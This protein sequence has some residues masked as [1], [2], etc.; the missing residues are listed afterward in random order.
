MGYYSKVHIAVPIKD[1]VAMESLLEDY[2][3]S[4]EFTIGGKDY[5]YYYSDELKWYDEFE[6]VKPVNTFI[7]AD[8]YDDA[9]VEGRAM[10]SIGEDGRLG[11]EVGDWFS[12]FELE[13]RIVD[14]DIRSKLKRKKQWNT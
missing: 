1:K 9:K 13:T 6:D 7:Q 14:A 2:W 4:F 3:D 12:I 10:I 11:N 8:P 5:M